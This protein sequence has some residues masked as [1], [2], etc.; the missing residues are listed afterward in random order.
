MIVKGPTPTV[1][2]DAVHKPAAG[3]RALKGHRKVFMPEAGKFVN[4]PIYDRYSLA[5]RAR[6]RGPA[7]IEEH[8]STV[9]L[10]PDAT[11]EVDQH[12]NLHVRLGGAKPTVRRGR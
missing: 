9:V 4:C 10:G 3:A 8:E 1:K 11:I 12:C 5:A 2:L 7:V 6:L